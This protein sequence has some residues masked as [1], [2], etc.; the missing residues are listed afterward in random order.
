[1]PLEDVA[2][3]LTNS[4]PRDGSAPMQGALPMGG[5]RITGLAPAINDGDAVR[6]DQAA[7]YS[8]FLESLSRLSPAA[9]DFV[10][11]PSAN[12]AA[13]LGS[14]SLGR[15]M[16][17]A[18]NPLAA[19]DLINAA[20]RSVATNSADGLMSAAD[21]A[22]LDTLKE[23]SATGSAP[24]YGCRA[25]VNFNG[26]TGTIIGQGNVASVTR[27]MVGDYTITYTTPLPIGYAVT[28]SARS[29]SDTA[30]RVLDPRELSA[31]SVRVRVIQH[32]AGLRDSEFVSLALIG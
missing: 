16:L 20:S 30:T 32:G 4:L 2:A 31:T 9:N 10:W 6:K 13:R 21:K 7:P 26:T 25:W 15:G 23:V 17:G 18:P 29:D 28:G 14:T 11:A 3:A 12:T 1:M 19:R 22:K 8:P 5:F 27:N 24:I